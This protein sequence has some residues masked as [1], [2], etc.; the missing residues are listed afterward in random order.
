MT[1]INTRFQTLGEWAKD[2]EIDLDK[3]EIAL[4]DYEDRIRITFYH[5][6][7]TPESFRAVK[8][9]IGGF[10]PVKFGSSASTLKAQTTINNGLDTD[11]EF[12]LAIHWYGAYTCDAVT[13]Y[14]CTPVGFPKKSPEDP[15][16]TVENSR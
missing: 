9:A 2:N 8:Q 12:I 15:E 5:Y 6:N 7:E 14:N 16:V 10:P 1:S 4:S 11:S 3:V 13:N